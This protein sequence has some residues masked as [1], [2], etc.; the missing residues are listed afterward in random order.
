DL[1]IAAVH[2]EAV[3]RVDEFLVLAEEPVHAVVV[4]ARLLSR[5]ESQDEVTVGHEAFLLEPHEDRGEDRGA[6]LDVVDAPTV[7]ESVLLRQRERVER[8]VLLL[9]LPDVEVGEEEDGAGRALAPQP[10]DEVRVRRARGADDL[11]VGRCV[12]GG[13]EPPGQCLR[14]LRRAPVLVRRVGLDELLEEVAAQ[15]LRRREVRGRSCGGRDEAQQP[16]LAGRFR[17]PFRWLATPVPRGLAHPRLRAPR[18]PQTL[19][20]GT[21]RGRRA[22]CS[23]SVPQ[24]ELR[25]RKPVVLL[26]GASGE[27][28]HGLIER[29]AGDR[30]RAIITLDLRPLDAAYAPLV[31][32]Q[33]VGSI[34]DTNLLERI[35]AEYEVQ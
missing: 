1:R 19:T 11:D 16:R 3:G 2:V 26:T 34:L 9:R 13:D 14:G 12:A 4:A 35:L 7:E 18:R 25:V 10:R 29:L 5:R 22:V 27:I 8:P 20:R 17:R 23:G 31:A 30:S 33:Y 15:L 6:V 32:Q 24:P 21:V 28:G